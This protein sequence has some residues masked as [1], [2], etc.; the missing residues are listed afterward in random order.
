VLDKLPK[1]L[2][3]R[4]KK[5]LHEIFQA[6][7]KEIAEE[8]VRAFVKEYSDR[9]PKAVASLLKDEEKLLTYYGISTHWNSS[10]RVRSRDALRPPRNTSRMKKR[11][12]KQAQRLSSISTPRLVQDSPTMFGTK[13]SADH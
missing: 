11:F 9:Y 6:E 1:R 4:A 3:P 7:T 13:Q 10:G 2:Q 8:Q 5:H 12:A